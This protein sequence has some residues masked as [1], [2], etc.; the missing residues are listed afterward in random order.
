MDITEALTAVRTHSE[1]KKFAQTIDLIVNLKSIDMKKPESR[2]SREIVL[3]H[4][5]GK[6]ARV[7][8]IADNRKDFEPRMGKDDITP[9]E[10]DKKAAKRVCREYDF[11]MCEPQLMVLIGKVLGR[12]LGPI[13]KM[14]RLLPPTADP[15][16]VAEELSHS[17]RVRVK[18]SPNL[19]CA[20]GPETMS[21]EY[22]INNAKCVIDDI[23]KALPAKAQIRNGYLKL[24]MGKPVKF[25]IKM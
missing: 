13:G 7:C 2:F 19:M 6:S 4:A 14:P 12:Y 3:P 18:D 23:K 21:D 20:I 25:E 11:F 24:T 1:K 10:R 5:S 9:L 15:N 8:L 17:V 16:T 22:I